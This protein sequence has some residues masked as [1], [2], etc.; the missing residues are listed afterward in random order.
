MCKLFTRDTVIITVYMSFPDDFSDWDVAPD[1]LLIQEYKVRK[2]R[3]DDAQTK[4]STLYA[5]IAIVMKG[6][7]YKQFNAEKCCNR[8]GDLANTFR[9]KYDQVRFQTGVGKDPTDWTYY[10]EFSKLFEGSA[11]LEPQRLVNMGSSYSVTTRTATSTEQHGRK[12]QQNKRV[13]PTSQ[14]ERKV[15]VGE[16]LLQQFT[17]MNDL[18]ESKK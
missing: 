5:E 12:G 9:E 11:S 15:L 14:K 13:S 18:L 6:K 10:D 1:L 7:G 2:P 8:M 3:F 17:R 16:G 4:A